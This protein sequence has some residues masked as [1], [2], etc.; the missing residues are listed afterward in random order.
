MYFEVAYHY[1]V[2]LLAEFSYILCFGWPSP[3]SP[4]LLH[5]PT[6]LYSETF[7]NAVFHLMS[8]T[9]GYC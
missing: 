3:P 8:H 9:V 4:P 1:E 2:K 6:L 5:I 7:S